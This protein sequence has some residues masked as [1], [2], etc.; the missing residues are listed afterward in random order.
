MVYFDLLTELWDEDAPVLHFS[1]PSTRSRRC[2][3]GNV[4]VC[5]VCSA[6]TGAVDRQC[7]GGGI[8]RAL[9]GGGGL[10]LCQVLPQGYQP[11]EAGAEGRRKRA[12]EGPGIQVDGV[13]C[14]VQSGSRR[15]CCSCSRRTAETGS[16]SRSHLGERCRGST[17]RWRSSRSAIR[18]ADGPLASA[19]TGLSIN[20]CFQVVGWDNPIVDG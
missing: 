11:G 10:I 15:R 14:G 8:L 2:P 6:P 20:R 1:R 4:G 12:D 3:S 18:T 17:C 5:R 19:F 16:G 13:V 7:Q 9:P